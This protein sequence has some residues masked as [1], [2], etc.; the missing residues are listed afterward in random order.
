MEVL[1]DKI[2]LN[3]EER[4]QIQLTYDILNTIEDEFTKRNANYVKIYEA[5]SLCYA[6]IHKQGFVYQRGLKYCPLRIEILDLALESKYPSKVIQTALTFS[7]LP[8]EYHI[9]KNELF[10]KYICV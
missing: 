9:D 4:N 7:E 3:E 8:F 1:G 10:L 6:L 2:V 5:K